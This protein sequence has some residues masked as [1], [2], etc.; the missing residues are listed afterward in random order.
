[1]DGGHDGL[2][3]P[4][5]TQSQ[6][7]QVRRSLPGRRETTGERFSE[8]RKAR[9]FVRVDLVEAGYPVGGALRLLDQEAREWSGRNRPTKASAVQLGRSLRLAREAQGLSLRDAAAWATLSPRKACGCL[10]QGKR[11]ARLSTLEAIS[12]VYDVTFV[13]ADGRTDVRLPGETPWRKPTS[14]S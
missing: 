10:E 3:G 5:P 12:D 6:R 11:T 13:I 7:E 1:M 4:N 8:R 9:R 14:R 2:R